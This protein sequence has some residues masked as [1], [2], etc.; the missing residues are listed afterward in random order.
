KLDLSL[1]TANSSSK[2]IEGIT[3]IVLAIDSV[4]RY[5]VAIDSKGQQS[6]LKATA[7]QDLAKQLQILFDQHPD[8]TLVIKADGQT[9]HE[10]VVFCLDAARKIGLKKV[11]FAAEA[12]SS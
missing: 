4:G 9:P 8:G 5:N 2:P 1:P 7:P 12:G 6:E 10:S 3:N 11:R